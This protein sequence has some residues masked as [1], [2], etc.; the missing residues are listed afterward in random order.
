M[1]HL[2]SAPLPPFKKKEWNPSETCGNAWKA[3]TFCILRLRG[4]ME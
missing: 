2:T 4:E 1:N 3:L